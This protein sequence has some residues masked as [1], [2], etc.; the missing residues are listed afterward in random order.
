MADRRDPDTMRLLLGLGLDRD[1]EGH[2]RITKGEDFVLLGGSEGTHESMQEHVE[3][4][5]HSLKKL[6][7]NLQHATEAEVREAL[8]RAKR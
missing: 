8:E 2:A 7:T 1:P 3:R 6:G 4:L 5:Q